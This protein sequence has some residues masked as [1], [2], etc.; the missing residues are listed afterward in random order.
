MEKNCFIFLISL[1]FSISYSQHSQKGLNL[2]SLRKLA[3]NEET[4]LIGFDNYSYALIDSDK[5][6]NLT[7]NTYILM[8]NWDLSK[9]KENDEI[10]LNDFNIT[11]DITYEDEKLV[12]KN[13][14]FECSYDNK[15]NSEY[16]DGARFFH[17]NCKEEP[18]CLVRYVCHYNSTSLNFPTKIDLTTDFSNN[19]NVKINGTQISYESTSAQ[20]MKKD[21]TKM[22]YLI[23]NFR[24]FK[25]STF[26]SKSANYFKIEG[27]GFSNFDHDDVQLITMINGSPKTIPCKTTDIDDSQEQTH[28]YLETKGQS[29]FGNT[30]LKYTVANYTNYN[31][32]NKIFILDFKEGENTAFISKINTSS[33]KSKGLSTGATIA[34]IIPTCL[35]LIG[36]AGL[37]FLLA[38]KPFSPQQISN[39][40]NNTIGVASSDA[41]VHQ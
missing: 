14:E 26:I 12:R 39:L 35:V 19:N 10:K 31:R 4:I 27:E 25:N 18:Y 23:E 6:L 40:N 37:A 7:F 11:S 30:E 5:N 16:N 28:Y 8:K 38:R 22:N 1:L 24:I 36:V 13:V 17:D 2:K 21:I 33:S 20:A 3:N 9:I 29:N 34:I 41:V 32:E 15:S